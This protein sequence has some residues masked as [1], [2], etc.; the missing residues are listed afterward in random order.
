[1][2]DRASVEHSFDGLLTEYRATI[3]PTVVEGWCDLLEGEQ[4]S[5]SRMYV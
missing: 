3:L 2:S 1:M 4:L 5:M